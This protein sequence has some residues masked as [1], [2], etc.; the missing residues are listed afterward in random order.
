MCDETHLN[1]AYR[2]FCRLGLEGAVGKLS[3]WRK[4]RNS[5]V[6]YGSIL[7][8]WNWA[9]AV[10]AVKS[11]DSDNDMPPGNPI[12]AEVQLSAQGAGPAFATHVCNVEGDPETGHVRVLRYTA[13][14]DVGRVIP[15]LCLEIFRGMSLTNAERGGSRRHSSILRRPLLVLEV[16]RMLE[17]LYPSVNGTPFRPDTGASRRA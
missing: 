11:E 5:R 8:R 12:G 13:T 4:E 3:T 1:L 17:S 9:A 6:R 15:V 10:E 7:R 16:R 2:W 14:Q